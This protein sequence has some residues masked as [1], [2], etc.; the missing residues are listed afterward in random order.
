MTDEINAEMTLHPKGTTKRIGQRRWA[1]V[2]PKP[3][4]PPAVN[5]SDT[6]C[7]ECGKEVVMTPAKANGW[8]CDPC[9]NRWYRS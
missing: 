7:L 2:A 1:A 9:I 5:V 8:V 4:A 3:P 6:A